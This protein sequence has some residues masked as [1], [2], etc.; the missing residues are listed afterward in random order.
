M[1]LSM[2]LYPLLGT[3]STQEARPDLTEKLLPRILRIKT[4]NIE[5]C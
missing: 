5:I 4:D 1:S 2:M 3:G